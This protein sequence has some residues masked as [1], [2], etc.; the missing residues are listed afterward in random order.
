MFTL[1][2]E[3]LDGRDLKAELQADTGAVVVFEGHVRGRSHG[4]DIALLEYEAHADQATKEFERIAAEAREKFAV[5]DVR[6]VHRVGRAM[7]GEMA[8]WVAAVAP[9]RDAAF[10]ACRY[11]MDELKHRLPIWKKQHYTD[12]TSEWIMHHAPGTP[13]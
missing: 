7:P 6:C 2:A 8:V 4:R 13:G 12:G 11:A 1:S 5:T 10:D 3:P 9:H